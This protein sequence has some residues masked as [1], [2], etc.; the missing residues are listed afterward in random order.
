MREYKP[1]EVGVHR[2]NREG[3]MC[4]GA[5]AMYDEHT[6]NPYLEIISLGIFSFGKIK[7]CAES[8]KDNVHLT[9]YIPNYIYRMTGPTDR[10]NTQSF[11]AEHGI[12]H[13]LHGDSLVS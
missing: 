6:N 11:D 1:G 2:N 9:F 7:H 3:A 5:E 4:S 13:L 12:M 10:P 8:W